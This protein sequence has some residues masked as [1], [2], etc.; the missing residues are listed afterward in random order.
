MSRN[1]SFQAAA[2]NTTLLSAGLFLGRFLAFFIFRRLAHLEG[3]AGLGVW[4]VAVELTAIFIIAANFGL[5][6]LVTREVIKEPAR[7]AGLFWTSLQIRLVAGTVGYALLIGFVFLSGYD[8]FTRWAVLVMALGV[9]LEASAM[10]CD[11]LL[12][13]KERF[14]VQTLSQIISAI[15]YFGLGM[16]WL[17]QGRGLEGVI[18]AN[19]ISRAVRLLLVSAAV[20]P[21]LARR[22]GAESPAA[23]GS[24][25]LAKMAWPIFISTTLGVIAFKIDTVMVMQFLGEN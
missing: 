10:A 16:L 13:A 25:G 3:P 24:I 1:P 11:S 4:G 2:K 15:V 17:D 20:A 23:I 5:G 19:V 8:S 12:Q 9:F 22:P 21:S 7:T 18:W 14:R 6:A